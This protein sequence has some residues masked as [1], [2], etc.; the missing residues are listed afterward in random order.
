MY[1]KTDG[2]SRHQHLVL[3]AM[4]LLPD[5]PGL[6]AIAAHARVPLDE[7][8]R[9]FQDD[10][11][12]YIAAAEQALLWLNDRSVKAVVTVSPD[13]PLSQLGKLGEA[14]IDWAASNPDYFRLIAGSYGVNLIGNPRLQR[15]HDAMRELMQK[16]L[17]RAQDNGHL[18]A[19]ENIP[20]MV[21]SAR[22]F[23]YG[24][25]RMIVDQR[26]GEWYPE[27]PPR[28]AAIDVLHDFMRRIA[29]GSYPRPKA[30]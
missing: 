30:G 9:L 5:L 16:M 6:A 7:A 15:Y 22:S 18:A 13:D 17:E 8:R 12:V 21:I 10:E 28:Q 11:A 25:A 3:A 4:D 23:G 14:Y 27:V 26:M 20:L 19:D 29:R 24:L 1:G 2:S